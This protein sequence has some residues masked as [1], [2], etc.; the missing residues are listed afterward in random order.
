[1]VRMQNKKW[2]FWLLTGLILLLFLPCSFLS[3]NESLRH[4]TL[5][6]SGRYSSI[7]SVQSEAP[8]NAILSAPPQGI[9]PEC[10]LPEDALRVVAGSIRIN[11]MAQGQDRYQAVRLLTVL[12]SI[13]LAVCVSW[14]TV[15]E[16]VCSSADSLH[17]NI[18][19]IHQ[20]DGKKGKR[21]SV[22][23]ES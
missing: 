1:M 15:I 16:H 23:V 19:Y 18:Y 8:Q 12:L 4:I 5:R 11:N 17:Q 2:I 3:W 20:A 10:K 6:D 22:T 21:F 9:I 13:L 7:S 14:Q